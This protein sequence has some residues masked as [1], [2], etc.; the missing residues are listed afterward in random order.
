[1]LLNEFCLMFENLY[2]KEHCNI[3][4]HLHGHSHECLKDY[5]P[6]YSFWLFAFERLNGVL[7]SFHTNCHDLSLQIMRRFIR[8]K[9]FQLQTFC[10]EYKDDFSPLIEKCV[11]N[12]G[13]LKHTCLKAAIQDNTC[14]FPL[15]PVRESALTLEQRRC[16]SDVICCLYP[17]IGEC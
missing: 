13:S 1:M 17:D 11:Y 14:V 9:E 7:G 12:K 4:L 5:G 2:G 15:P 3:N 16:I 8:T 6:V 10:N